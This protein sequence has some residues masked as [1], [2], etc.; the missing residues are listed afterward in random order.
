MKLY[1]LT[2]L[3]LATT[4]YVPLMFIPEPRGQDTSAVHRRLEVK[5]NESQAEVCPG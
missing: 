3:S 1:S 4:L 5:G 2:I